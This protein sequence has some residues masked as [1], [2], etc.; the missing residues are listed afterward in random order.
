M[1]N[2]MEFSRQGDFG[3]NKYRPVQTNLRA[4][5]VTPSYRSIRLF[6]LATKM[7]NSLGLPGWGKPFFLKKILREKSAPFPSA[8]SIRRTPM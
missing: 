3:E 7:A 2:F 8:G 4:T 6:F 5:C 1:G